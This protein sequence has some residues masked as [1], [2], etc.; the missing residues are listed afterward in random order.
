MSFWIVTT[1]AVFG[2]VDGTAVITVAY[3][4]PLD[5]W[6]GVGL[7]VMSVVLIVGAISRLRGD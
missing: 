2:V 4:G 7:V 3:R 1:I 6:V 5:R